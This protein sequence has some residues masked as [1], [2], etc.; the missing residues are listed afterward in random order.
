[1]G[2]VIVWRQWVYICY[3]STG[4]IVLEVD[5]LEE[6]NGNADVANLLCSEVA[7]KYPNLSIGQPSKIF[8]YCRKISRAYKAGEAK[9]SGSLLASFR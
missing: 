1:M 3:N 9:L 2:F 4:C 7:K 8:R 6:F 5:Q